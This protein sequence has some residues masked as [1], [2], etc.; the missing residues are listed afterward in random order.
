M[1]TVQY[2]G[3][4]N[5]NLQDVGSDPKVNVDI[6]LHNPNPF[7]A[8]LKNMDLVLSSGNKQ[9]GNVELGKKVHMKRRSDFIVPIEM[10]ASFS[11][12]GALLKPGLETLLNDE[13]IPLEL[14]G[15]VTLTKFWIFRKTFQFDV[16]D[17]I[18]FNDVRIK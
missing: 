15:E 13:G 12:L 5:F 14:K 2:G 4:E 9:I 17:D 7:G 6:K 11:Q 18:Q 3:F 10:A 1:Q 8:T 16:H